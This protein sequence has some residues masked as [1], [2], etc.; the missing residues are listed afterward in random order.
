MRYFVFIYRRTVR[1]LYCN[2]NKFC[3]ISRNCFV[4]FFL[5]VCYTYDIFMCVSV[6]RMDWENIGNKNILNI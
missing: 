4:H 3:D 5:V 1:C 2:K 6:K